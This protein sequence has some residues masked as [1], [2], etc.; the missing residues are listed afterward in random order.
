MHNRNHPTR[1]DFVAGGLA[2]TTALLP[3]SAIGRSRDRQPDA[4]ASFLRTHFSSDW[5]DVGAPAGTLIAEITGSIFNYRIPIESVVFQEGGDVGGRF[6]LA[7]D[8]E[9]FF[10]LVGTGAPIDFEGAVRPVPLMFYL[11][12]VRW[13]WRQFSTDATLILRPRYPKVAPT[14][15]T[16]NQD[17]VISSMVA[18]YQEVPKTTANRT[19]KIN[20][21]WRGIGKSPGT[22]QPKLKRSNCTYEGHPEWAMR[23][24]RG[25]IFQQGT[26][27][28]V[29]DWAFRVGAHLVNTGFPALNEVDN[30]MLAYKGTNWLK[31]V[32]FQNC[33]FSSS[34]DELL[35]ITNGGTPF[36]ARNVRFTNCLFAEPLFDAGHPKGEFHN[37]GPSVSPNN[38]NVVFDNCLMLGNGG[39]S[40]IINKSLGATIRNCVIGHW[41]PNVRYGGTMCIFDTTGA[42]RQLTVRIEGCLYQKPSQVGTVP[43]RRSAIALHGLND[44]NT[45]FVYIPSTGR[46]RNHHIDIPSDSFVR[47]PLTIG[48]GIHLDLGSVAEVVR[49]RPPFELAD[50]Y[51]LMPTASEEQRRAVLARVLD[52]AGVRRRDAEGNLIPGDLA[53]NHYDYDIVH[54]FRTTG[55]ARVDLTPVQLA[56]LYGTNWD[57]VGGSLG[58]GMT[59]VPSQMTTQSRPGR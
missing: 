3:H 4:R 8:G 25:W 33:S 42:A 21:S 55:T 1:R 50:D 53:L 58:H 10:L 32:I 59:D 2:A 26:N 48:D 43:P 41:R 15:G 19:I 22:A 39:R 17:I 16:L 30:L 38:A 49:D 47:D 56:S 7:Q 14:G 31:D 13:T 37:L 28:V 11:P 18:L 20:P 57:G 35:R 52:Y 6:A 45:A 34:N 24:G 51:G 44:P 40:P 27:I 23:H 12:A 36:A 46:Y 54:A 9:R 5:V 29:R